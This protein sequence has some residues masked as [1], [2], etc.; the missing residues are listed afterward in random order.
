M[1]DTDSLAAHEGD[2]IHPAFEEPHGLRRSGRCRWYTPRDQGIMRLEIATEGFPLPGLV[3]E[4]VKM[5]EVIERRAAHARTRRAIR[6][7][8][9]STRM[10]MA[11]SITMAG[12]YSIEATRCQT[13]A[14]GH[15]LRWEV[16]ANAAEKSMRKA[17]TWQDAY[18]QCRSATG[19]SHTMGIC[20]GGHLHCVSRLL[21]HVQGM[22]ELPLNAE[23]HL[24]AA[25]MRVMMAQ[26]RSL[27]PLSYKIRALAGEVV[28]QLRVLLHVYTAN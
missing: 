21:L 12:A 22:Y 2:A 14:A 7:G 9:E 23:H 10:K 11:S 17:R 15:L 24:T 20:L 27:A 28:R 25:T 18:E 1:N 13:E 3:D 16:L 5:V 6:N 26:S 8:I 19:N 4:A